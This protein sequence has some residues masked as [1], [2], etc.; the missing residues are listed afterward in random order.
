MELD[1]KVAIVTGASRGVGAA[2]A[3]ALAARGVRVACAARATDAS[4]LPIPGTIDETVRRITDAGGMAVTVPTNLADDASTLAMVDATVARYGRVDILVNNAAITFPGDLDLPMKR[5]DLVFDVD[6]RAPV[7]ATAAV[8]AGMR[9]RG[10]GAIVNVSSLAALNYFPGLMAYGMA[11][12][13]LEHFTMS[14]AAQLRPHGIAVNTFR[15]DIPVA[16][17]GFLMNLPDLDHS[18]WEPPEVAAEGICWM[19][20]QP[21]SWTGHNVGMARLRAEHGIMASRAAREHRQQPH[22]VTDTH[23]RP[24][25]DEPSA[26]D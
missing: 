8:V 25:G 13:A 20:E 18:D 15:I 23:L 3:I 11:K 2:T 21:P 6:L 12:A 22:V 26:R 7:L 9:E 4:P 24:V 1:G 19:L 5:F 14:A 17:E 16:S 10:E